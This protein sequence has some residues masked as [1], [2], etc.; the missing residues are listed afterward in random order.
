M[1]GGLADLLTRVKFDLKREQIRAEQERDTWHA[2]GHEIMSPLQSLMVLHGQ[3]LDPSHRYVKRMQQAVKVLY[4]SA[5][6]SEA[7]ESSQLQLGIL[8]L[9]EF[10]G[11][12][13]ENAHFAGIEG[14]VFA[15]PLVKCL[16][17]ADE[18]SLE[19]VV[20]HVLNNA[21]RYRLPGSIIMLG[22]ARVQDRGA[23]EAVIQI[24]NQG[25]TIPL[26][27]IDKI[28]EYGVSELKE[29][30]SSRAVAPGV[31][32]RL[33]SSAN[34]ANN[35]RRGQGLFVAKTYMAK[36]QGGIRARNTAD[37]VMFELRLPSA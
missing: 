9:V 33:N 11:N 5:S 21:K 15:S 20:T 27:L 2:V 22:L 16:V 8:E 12:V 1:A 10:L 18:Y 26:E 29:I 32:T 6:P 30:D 37:G 3:E 4:G 14:L 13:A 34:V 7:I 35:E 23:N 24:A 28:F 36:M 17:H 19:D 31:E 25:P